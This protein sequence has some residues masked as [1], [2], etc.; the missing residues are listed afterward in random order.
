MVERLVVERQGA[1]FA[2]REDRVEGERVGH[3]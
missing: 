1:S 2:R 3:R